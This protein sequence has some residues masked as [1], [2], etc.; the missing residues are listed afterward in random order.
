MQELSMRQ[1][2]IMRHLISAKEDIFRI[3]E[4]S[5]IFQISEKTLRNDMKEIVCFSKSVEGL[6]ITIKRGLGIRVLI[7]EQ[8]VNK[9]NKL[10]E[11]TTFS[12]ERELLALNIATMLLKKKSP[13]S[14]KDMSEIY[15]VSVQEIKNTLIIVQSWLERFEILLTVKRGTGVIISGNELSLRNAIKFITSLQFD[16]S[17]HSISISNY[18]GLVEYK[19]VTSIVHKYLADTSVQTDLINSFILHVLIV[20]QRIKN[21]HYIEVSNKIEYNDNDNDIKKMIDEIAVQLSITI[22][23]NEQDYLILHYP[24]RIVKYSSGRDDREK[25]VHLLVEEMKNE[26]MIDFSHDEDLIKGL[27]LHMQTSS[28]SY[29]IMNPLLKDIKTTYPFMYSSVVNAIRNLQTHVNLTFPESEMGYITM[30][31]QASYEKMKRDHSKKV[32]LVCHYG[33]GIS[34]MLK[35]KLENLYSNFDIAGVI[36]QS[37]IH[38]FLE[39]YNI[40]LIITTIDIKDVNIEVIKISPL[41][42]KEDILYL[43]HYSHKRKVSSTINRPNLISK[44]VTP[45]SLYPNL[46]LDDKYKIIEYMGLHLI[47]NNY[48]HGSYVHSVSQREYLSAT[49]IGHGIAIPHG[50]SSLVHISTIS[51]ATL[52]E[53][54]I[55]GE[56]Y[57]DI[58]FMIALTD[59]DKKYYR[60]VFKEVHYLME[61]KSLLNQLRIQKS[62]VGIMKVLNQ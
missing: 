20:I 48:V 62:R 17:G 3:Q 2:K 52:E 24:G 9:T 61:E 18:F 58:V 5:E 41:L 42:S 46:K 34:Q 54:I 26:A 36:S 31:F 37:E 4:L 53:P 12:E 45:F 11:E 40:D 44:F 23:A 29:H 28:Q 25:I 50:Q 13:V 57:I 59:E 22:P 49:A 43:N 38:Q 14:I 8:N 33:I 39:G 7:D 51:I 47:K 32:L 27:T 16:T 21:K 55:W 19:V 56:S 30:H 1:K 10:L 15:H 6:S 60:E 35:V